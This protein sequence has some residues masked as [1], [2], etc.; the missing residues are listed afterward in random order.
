MAGQIEEIVTVVI[1]GYELRGWQG[2]DIRRSMQNAAIAFTL[3][4]AWPSW[5]EPARRLR[6][7]E[8]V[9]IYTSPARGVRRPGGGD[10][11]C[12]GAVDTYEADI[13]EGSSKTVTLHGRSHARD[14][15]DCPPC[16]HKTGRVE[17]RTLLDA[18]RD[19]G[20]E[21]DLAWDADVALERIEKIQVRPGESLF[22]AIERE[23]RIEALMLMGRPDGSILITRAGTKRHAGVLIEGRP[24][25]N[26]VSVKLQAESDRSEIHVRGQ[27]ADGWDQDALRQSEIVTPELPGAAKRRHRGQ[28]VYVEGDRK[29]DR[30]KKRG[31][32]HHLRQFAGN[33]VAPR[34]SRWRDDGGLLWEP[35]R[36]MALV[37]PSEELDV[38]FTLS[39]VTFRQ[40][41]GDN[42]GTRADLV[43]VDPRTHGGGEPAAGKGNGGGGEYD[44]GEEL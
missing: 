39:E 1:D 23:A 20:A 12:R 9:E 14:A 31:K 25:V 10:L 28:I 35:G 16:R 44:P 19:L 8:E 43:F 15:I 34:V 42:G 17:N 7:A 5:S 36:L 2:V 40:E 4:A 6:T 29:P 37:V 22:A 32:W 21:F 3:K 13:G 27:R 18:A 41:I 33:L 38:D 11:L 30:L 24:P 26:R